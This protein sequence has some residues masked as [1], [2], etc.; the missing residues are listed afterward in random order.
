MH[1][2]LAAHPG[3]L[4][5]PRV[6]FPPRALAVDLLQRRG[7]TWGALLTV[8]SLLD[9]LSGRGDHQVRRLGARLSEVWSEPAECRSVLRHL[10]SG[11]LWPPML[12]L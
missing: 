12:P 1:Q 11:A 9:S 3:S 7:W 6:T 4:C 8:H 5:R 2:L 10:Q